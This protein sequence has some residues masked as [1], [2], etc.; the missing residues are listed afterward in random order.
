MC[1]SVCVTLCV[2]ETVFTRGK[3]NWLGNKDGGKGCVINFTFLQAGHRMKTTATLH[4]KFIMMN[5]KESQ[6]KP[7]SNSCEKQN[8]EVHTHLWT[9]ASLG[10]ERDTP[11]KG[12]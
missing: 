8:H 5:A 9:Y 10:L 3:E 7:S 11:K 1:M 2:I 12:A 4:S 6:W